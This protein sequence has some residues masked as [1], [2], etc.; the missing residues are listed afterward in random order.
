M[1]KN[2]E[3]SLRKVGDYLKTDSDTIF[4]IPAY[5]RAY[6][7]GIDRC[8]KLWNDVLDYSEKDEK[9]PYFFG[10]IILSCEKNDSE[11]HLIDGQQR[12]TTFFLL[13]KALLTRINEAILHIPKTDTDSVELKRGLRQRR[14]DIIQILYKVDEESIPDEPDYEND[15]RLYQN[16][17][18]FQNYSMLEQFETDFNIIMNSVNIEDIEKSP[19]LSKIE[20][21]KKDNKYSNFFRNYKF[22][23]EEARNLSE[24]QIN[25]IS[26]TLIK[27]CEVIE[28]RSWQLEQAI[29][30]F[31][32]LNSDGMPLRDADIISSK[33]FAAAKK[34]NEQE[35][36]QKKWQDF[37]DRSSELEKKDITDIDSLLMQYMYYL[38][39]LNGNTINDKGEANVTM[40]SLRAYFS[41]KSNKDDKDI[42]GSEA[43]T[44]PMKFAD[45]VI[46]LAKSWEKAYT[47]FP[48]VQ[49]LLKINENAKFF[50]ASFLYR[51]KDAIPEEDIKVV[52]ESLM[53]LFAIMDATNAN[54]SSKDFKMFL[55]K[56][57]VKMLDPEIPVEIIRKDFTNHLSK[58][59]QKD[60]EEYLQD[61][62]D[63]ALVPLN[64][65]IYAKENDPTFNLLDKY[66]IEHIM[67]SSGRNQQSVRPNAGIQDG[68]DFKTIVNLLGNKIILE[69]SINRA[70]GADWFQSKILGDLKEKKGYQNS[71]YPFAKALVNKYEKEDKKY[72]TKTDIENATE[73]ASKR[74]VG[75]IFS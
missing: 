59:S 50:L 27:S 40:P 5:Q 19:N 38:R 41:E 37:I 49:V 68:D 4:V 56:E 71:K 57:Q 16:V 61:Y 30:M 33:L 47:S 3:P 67:P 51:F 21:R 18:L 74:I 13:L 45:D 62:T 15:S 54:Y 73:A 36:F 23:L 75:F 24:S 11:L 1:A 43:I 52:S 20:G 48:C 14:I 39:A 25:T 26:K 9:D 29:T 31:N 55:F 69:Y 35:A 66:D 42:A 7:W 46:M 60:I 22:F 65:Y 17:P 32:S 63:S 64:E 12:T 6:S 34:N 72:W 2:I 53:K 58:W 44:N 8:G 28:I 70:V 10:T